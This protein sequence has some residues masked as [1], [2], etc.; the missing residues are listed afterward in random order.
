MFLLRPAIR[1]KTHLIPRGN[2]IKLA[3]YRETALCLCAC[4]R[5]KGELPA[6]G[7]IYRH[8]WPL[9]TS[10]SPAFPWTG[11]SSPQIDLSLRTLFPLRTFSRSWR[12]LPPC[13]ENACSQA[14]RRLPESW[15]ASF[16]GTLRQRD[17]TMDF[18]GKSAEQTACKADQQRRR[19]KAQVSL[20]DY[21][22]Q[23]CQQRPWNF[24]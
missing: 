18:Q 20:G 14:E 19:R 8:C 7:N 22:E 23:P 1:G 6:L 4:G 21:K 24:M 11:V 13:W 10:P 17:W 9:S 2:A 16:R 5:Q 15:P 12:T 3:S